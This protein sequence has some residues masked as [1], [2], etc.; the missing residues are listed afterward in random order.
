MKQIILLFSL[1][2]SLY[3]NGQD[4]DNGLVAYYPLNGNA[5]DLSGN[6]YDGKIFGVVPTSDFLGKANNAMLFNGIDNYI[7]IPSKV[8][9]GLKECTLSFWVNLYDSKSGTIIAKQHDGVNSISVLGVGYIPSQQNSNIDGRISYHLSNS[10]STNGILYQIEPYKFHHIVI[11]FNSREIN[12]Y[13]NGLLKQTYNG[14]YNIPTDNFPTSTTL[15]AWLNG[16]GGK[17]LKGKLDEM[18][19][20]N[21]ELS[22]IE[23][24]Q[25]FGNGPIAKPLN[26]EVN[27][28]NKG[29]QNSNNTIIQTGNSLSQIVPLTKMKKEISSG[30][31][32]FG[33]VTFTDIEIKKMSNGREYL[34]VEN[35]QFNVAH[36]KYSIIQKELPANIEQPQYVSQFIDAWQKYSEL[37]NIRFISYLCT[38]HLEGLADEYYNYYKNYELFTLFRL[39]HYLYFDNNDMSNSDWEIFKE[40]IRATKVEAMRKDLTQKL[41]NIKEEKNRDN[42]TLLAF[43]GGVYKYG[44]KVINQISESAVNS[45]DITSNNTN[46]Q[47]KYEVISSSNSKVSIQTNKATSSFISLS[48]KTRG[49]EEKMESNY[50]SSYTTKSGST[51][52]FNSSVADNFISID[53]RYFPITINV[54]YKGLVSEKDVSTTIKIIDPTLDYVIEVLSK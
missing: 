23:I 39:P 25:L 37:G 19:I 47:S 49:N 29:E 52:S 46:S 11:S 34:I 16:G 32:I 40:E 12:F 20:Y 17:Y 9:N 24:K 53:S 8:L 51:K 4:I 10:S 31:Y 43:L 54:K 35:P 3:S 18:R 5:K 38:F 22:L 6:G 13:V 44:E 42:A 36:K 33:P 15:G 41:K 7:E 2:I 50:F 21:R 1:I 45:G 26:E 30:K 27:T 28:S 48:I 14:N